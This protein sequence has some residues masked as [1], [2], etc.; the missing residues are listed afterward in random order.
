MSNLEIKIDSDLDIDVD[1]FH[2]ADGYAT[3]K[4]TINI[5]ARDN[6][7]RNELAWVRWL[8][9]HL[10][11][12]KN[13]TWKVK[14]EVTCIIRKMIE[15]YKKEHGMKDDE[16]FEDYL[17]SKNITNHAEKLN[18]NDN[19]TEEENDFKLKY[20]KLKLS[21]DNLVK[22]FLRPSTKYWEE[23]F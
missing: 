23:E 3:E 19:E 14:K 16:F 18:K 10:L 2:K 6:E 20:E 1:G 21:Y 8:I 12:L 11:L 13:D 9:S 4:M 22:D 17:D 5:I 15:D 7:A